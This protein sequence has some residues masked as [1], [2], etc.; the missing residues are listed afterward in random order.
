MRFETQHVVL[1]DGIDA[2]YHERWERDP[3]S[4]GV[5]WAMSLSHEDARAAGFDSPAVFIAR[6]GDFFMFARSRSSRAQAMLASDRGKRLVDVVRDP[7]LDIGD[8]RELLDFEISLGRVRS[9]DG[10]RWT[11]ELS[12]LPW[13]EGQA[14]FEPH[15]GAAL[16]ALGATLPR[17]RNPAP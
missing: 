14:A 10:A 5:S 9:D 7:A 17:D 2:V 1:E 11:V 4:V 13:R 6:T 15:V 16:D 8:V 3:L 12:T